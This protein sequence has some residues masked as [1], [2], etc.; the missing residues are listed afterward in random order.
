M[1]DRPPAVDEA[2]AFAPG[3]AALQ[4]PARAG[5]AAAQASAVLWVHGYTT[6][7]TAWDELWSLLP[8]RRHIGIDLPGHGASAPTEPALS[9]RA[10]ALRLADAALAQGV[11]DIVGLS[12]GSMVALEIVLARPDAFASLTMAAPA[13]AGGPVAADVGR[14]YQELHA[15]Y[16]ARGPGPW[17]TALWM[18]GPPA[19]FAHA[20]PALHRRLAAIIDRHRW[21]EFEPVGAGFQQ[22]VRTRQDPAP[23]ARS[24]CRP[25]W[26]VG[27][28]ELPAFRQ[29]ATLLQALRPDA[30]IDEL[31][32]AGHLCLLNRP[33]E[34][35]ALLTRHWDG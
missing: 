24:P 12:F 21:S 17:M 1:A 28:H 18:Q 11:R 15:L 5:N 8:Q 26:I 10:L 35:S 33:A 4:R 27:E 29:T 30:R 9:L 14:R 23:L 19:T 22:W 6:D 25:L 7:A 20:G 13:L 32:G 31:P 3:I 34:S 2:I 16:R